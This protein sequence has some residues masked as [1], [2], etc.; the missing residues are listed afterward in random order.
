MIEM[1]YATALYESRNRIT[2]AASRATLISSL[3]QLEDVAP[4]APFARRTFRQL[5]ATVELKRAA[6]TAEQPRAA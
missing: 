1:N 3:G 2:L 5:T 4:P 6:A